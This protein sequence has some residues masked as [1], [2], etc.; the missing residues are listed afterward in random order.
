MT[1][2]V[3]HLLLYCF[4]L[5][6]IVST[7]LS[8]R[9]ES[10]I[11]FHTSSCLGFELQGMSLWLIHPLQSFSFWESVLRSVA[12]LYLQSLQ[13]HTHLKVTMR[14]YFHNPLWCVHVCV[15]SLKKENV[16]SRAVL[17]EA[18]E[19]NALIWRDCRYT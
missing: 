17:S 6:I 15:Q 9:S 12:K 13:T 14:V 10:S 3:V 16:T 7:C 1:R 2:I 8:V 11:I 4:V 19:E 18:W 5:S